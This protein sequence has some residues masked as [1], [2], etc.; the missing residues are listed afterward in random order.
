[1]PKRIYIVDDSTVTRMFIKSTIVDFPDVEIEEFSNGED[2]LN[3]ILEEQPDLLILDSVMPKMDGLSVLENLKNKGLIFPI[4]FC[5][6]DIQETTKN[7]AISLGIT[8][9]I[10]KPIQKET[11]YEKVNEILFKK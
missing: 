6:A 11:I 5:T 8:E 1:M 10:N 7:K 9:F 2:V 4:I 3:R